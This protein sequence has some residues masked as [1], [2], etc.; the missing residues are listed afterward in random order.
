MDRFTVGVGFSRMFL[1]QPHYGMSADNYRLNFF[2]EHIFL[3]EFSIGYTAESEVTHICTC[4]N[5]MSLR[6]AQHMRLFTEILI[7]AIHSY[8]IFNPMLLKP[9]SN[10]TLF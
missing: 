7:Y 9:L 10:V 1:P 2:Y 3:K 5:M 8:W 4:A 6:A